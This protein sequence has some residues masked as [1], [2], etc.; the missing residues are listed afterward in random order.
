MNVF[1]CFVKYQDPRM[2]ELAFFAARDIV[3][4]EE[5]CFDYSGSNTDLI[6]EEGYFFLDCLCGSRKCRKYLKM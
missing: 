1:P 4:G 2:H 5:L 6:K 3:P